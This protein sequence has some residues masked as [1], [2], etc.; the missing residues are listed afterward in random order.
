MTEC[1]NKRARKIL[2]IGACA[3]NIA[4]VEL[5]DYVTIQ[6]Y[7]VEFIATCRSDDRE[8]E[9][10]IA[11]IASG[12]GFRVYR[13]IRAND[14]EFID[15]IKAHSID[16]MLLLWWPEII[17]KEAIH[18]AKI[19]WV[20][21]HPSLLPYDQ[22]KH[23][24]VW[25]I[26]NGNPYGV[27][28]HLINGDIDRGPILFQKEIAVNITDTGE[29]LYAKSFREQ[30]NFFREN[31]AN[32]VSMNFTP[33]EQEQHK[34]TYHNAKDIDTINAIDLDKEYKAGNL[35]DIIRAQTFSDG[36]CSYITHQGNKYY[37]KL[38]I[39][40]VQNGEDS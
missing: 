36:R 11:H 6:P 7:P 18:A 33:K 24:Y 20:N 23:G 3:A 9:K 15:L 1:T 26:I 27:T 14:T 35:I 30:I 16:L 2:K 28:I 17:S 22:G 29:S 10:E 21:N 31:Y 37:L 12:R 39:E 34:R 40:K 8:R 38:K 19:G 13:D 25:S 5:V 4:G 32:L